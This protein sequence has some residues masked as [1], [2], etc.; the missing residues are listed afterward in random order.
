MNKKNEKRTNSILH[1]R[2]TLA[3]HHMIDDKISGRA[4]RNG[5]TRRG[6]T[7]SRGTEHYRPVPVP[8]PGH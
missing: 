5:Q 8:V 7:L 6:H 3:L 4:A 1:V 2:F